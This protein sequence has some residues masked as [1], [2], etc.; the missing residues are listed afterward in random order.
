MLLGGLDY[1][2]SDWDASDK[3]S[4]QGGDF[5]MTDPDDMSDETRFGKP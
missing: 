1:G 5:C 3:E 4:I 2:A